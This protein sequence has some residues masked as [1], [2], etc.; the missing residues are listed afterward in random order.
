[1]SSLPLDAAAAEQ[2][3][4]PGLVIF[5]AAV[6]Q[7]LETMI[8]IAGS[9][10]RLRPHCKTHKM[11]AV[12]RLELERG[13]TR[14]KAATIAEAEMLARSGVKDIV[15]AYHVVGPNL[16]RVVRFRRA[17]PDVRFSVTADDAR[18]ITQL[19]QAVSEA[20]ERIGV[21]LDL[22]PGRDRTG[23]CPGDAAGKLYSL[24]ATT[25][26]LQPEGFH[27]YDGHHID[28]AAEARRRAV[29]QDWQKVAAFR[30]EVV[31][32]GLEVPRIL[33]GGTPTFPAYSG[34]QD[35]AIELCPGTCVLHDAG[36]RETYHDLQEFIPAAQLLTRVIS[37]PKPN[38]VTF[39]LG[40]KAIAS[41]PPMGK[42][43]CLPEIPDAVQVLHNEEHLV[44]ETAMAAR[45]QPG[46]WVLAIPRHVCPTVALHASAT[47][48][49]NGA[50]VDIWEV[51]AR[52]RSLTI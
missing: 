36:Y 23:V 50:I 46:D 40:T 13:I 17:F 39:D 15:L 2:I 10:Q 27:Y 9:A 28:S 26:G 21:L 37:R 12:T 24:I 45:Y 42:R 25:P 47:V 35:P 34:L 1:M 43:V 22:N 8:R 5:R 32:A 3:F 33:C 11:S 18:A 29:E 7:N 30:D 14:H 41:D 38:R 51:T 19:G 49:E 6:I 16:A 20:G 31:A 52:N 4:S 44:V 48:I